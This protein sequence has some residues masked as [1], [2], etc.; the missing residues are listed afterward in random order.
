MPAKS[1]ASVSAESGIASVGRAAGICFATGFLP[2]SIT[3]PSST[4]LNGISSTCRAATLVIADAPAAT[5]ISV[6]APKIILMAMAS[7]G[8]HALGP[9]N[10]DYFY[11]M[12][13]KT[14]YITRRN[15]Q[16]SAIVLARCSSLC[17]S[18]AKTHATCIAL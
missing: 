5:P 15:A 12:H 2:T 14:H 16:C 9:D 18:D 10:V 11:T 3:T 13:Y 6:F 7:K 1:W 4:L 8:P 17:H